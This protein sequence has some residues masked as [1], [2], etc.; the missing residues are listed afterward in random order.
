M[1]AGCAEDA[2]QRRRKRRG[3]RAKGASD[4]GGERR[5]GHLE[6]SIAEAR[7]SENPFLIF[8]LFDLF[9]LL[10]RVAKH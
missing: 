10:L 3:G 7:K 4:R 5:P 6:F 2:R 1:D 9:D 8:T